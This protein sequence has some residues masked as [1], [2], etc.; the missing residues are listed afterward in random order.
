MAEKDAKTRRQVAFSR[1]EHEQVKLIYTGLA[2]VAGLVVLVLAV[3]L[4]QTYIFEPSSAIAV[5]E[6]DEITVQEYRDRVRYERFVLEEQYTQIAQQI[7]ALEEQGNEQFVQFYNQYAQQIL[8]QR[9]MVDQQTL[10]QMIV[11]RLIVE[12]AAQR[13]IVV[14]DEEVEERINSFLAS[15][16]GGLTEAQASETIEAGV[17]ATA[18]ASQWTPTPTLIPSPTLEAVS[19]ITP[20]ITPADT[21][22]PGPTPTLNVIA[23]NELSNQYSTWLSTLNEQADVSGEQYRQIIK[24]NVLSEKVREDIGDEV[25][26]MALQS[27]ARHILLS[28]SVEPQYDEEGNPI[29]LSEE[30]QTEAEA[31]VKTEAKALA[32]DLYERLQAGEDFAQ[33]AE[34]Y[35]DDPGSAAN[36]GDLGFVI[37]GE[38]VESV[39]EAVFNREIGE[40]TEPIES[41]F[42]WHIIEVIEREERE[43]SPADYDQ[44]KSEHFNDWLTET[45]DQATDAGAIEDYWTPDKAPKDTFFNR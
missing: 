34:E 15:R 39:D 2:I 29:E 22:T 3:G 27:R 25:D 14:T 26:N 9:S 23:A 35:S 16:A 42:G 12:E 37:S 19:G 1:K 28:S 18:T 38:F 30:E 17:N 44:S 11:E 45:R 10:D 6:G 36:G 32:D 24:M 8:Q 41:Q 33:L 7:Q 31:R 43:L 21:P 40:I 4:F 13:E 5:V 20:T